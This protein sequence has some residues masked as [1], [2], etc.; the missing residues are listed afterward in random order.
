MDSFLDVL[1]ASEPRPEPRGKRGD[2][3]NYAERLSRNIAT[4]LANLLRQDFDGILPDESGHGQESRART[5]RGPKKLDVNCSTPELGLGLGISVKTINYRDRGTRRYTKNYS[6]VDNELRAEAKDYHQRQP[7]SVLAA[8][9]FL[10]S[11]ACQDGTPKAPSSFGAAVRY[12]RLRGNRTDPRNE[13]E[14]FERVYIG[15]YDYQN[16][17]RGEVFFFN[18]LSRPPK[19]GRPAPDETLGLRGLIAEIAAAYDERNNP[20]FFWA[21]GTKD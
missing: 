11:D 13:E 6:R 18:A 9:I 17:N 14:L 5:A 4:L 21:N 7:Y 19:Q 12:F 20:P 2:K 3:K 15:V 8:V 10:P 1:E 16:E